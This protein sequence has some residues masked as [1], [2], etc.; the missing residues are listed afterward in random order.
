MPPY[1]TSWRSILIL[2]SHVFLCLPN[3]LFPSGFPTKTLYACLLSR[4]PATCPARLILH[5]ITRTKCSEQCRS[6]RSSLCSRLVQFS[7]TFSLLSSFNARC[8]VSHP[9]TITGHITMP[10]LLRKLQ[11]KPTQLLNMEWGEVTGVAW[12]G[13]GSTLVQETVREFDLSFCRQSW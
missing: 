6:L 5:L 10:L 8:Q 1:P 11:I 3:G 9:Y 13:S 7:N 12:E 2:P 4:T